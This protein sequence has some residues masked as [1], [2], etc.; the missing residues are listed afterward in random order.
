MILRECY[1]DSFP[2]WYFK[3]P[4]KG[5]EVPLSNWLKNDLK[6][7]V[8]DS[9]QNIVLESLNIENFNIV[10]NWKKEFYKGE[11]DN[12]WRLWVLI[13]YYHWAKNS[14]II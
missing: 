9:T 4:K 10:N 12:S 7:L 11:K 6:Y 8:E 5:F 2:D 1:E 13:S 14:N 3:M